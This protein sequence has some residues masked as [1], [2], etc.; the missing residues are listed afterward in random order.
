MPWLRKSPGR[1]SGHGI[2]CVA[3]TTCIAVPEWISSSWIKS[4]RRYDSKCEYIFCTI[5]NNS[6]CKELR[7]AMLYAVSCCIWLYD[8]KSQ[9]QHMYIPRLTYWCMLYLL[10]QLDNTLRPRQNGCQFLDDIFK[11]IFLNE[12]F[13]ISN[14]ISLKYFP[15]GII[16]NKP[17]LVQIMGCRRIGDKT[18]SEPMMA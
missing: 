13:K 3:Q 11:C 17:S 9:S 1:I 18:L 15:W 5:L 2:G 16:D 7:I 10:T 6:A 8:N 14:K 12:N 4:N